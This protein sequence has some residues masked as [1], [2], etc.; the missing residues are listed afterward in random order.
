MK[1]FICTQLTHFSDFQFVEIIE[2]FAFHPDLRGKNVSSSE[3][4]AVA[5][6]NFLFCSVPFGCSLLWSYLL[7]A[8]Y[9]CNL[10]RPSN[11]RDGMRQWKLVSTSWVCR[12]KQLITCVPSFPSALFIPKTG[13]VSCIFIGQRQ[14][15]HLANT[16]VSA[17]L[18]DLNEGLVKLPAD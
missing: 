8:T 14:A 12:P 17:T 15:K 10:E 4:S 1:C 18:R 2:I 7:R 3:L 13:I 5:E 6:G 11:G 16:Q 9:S